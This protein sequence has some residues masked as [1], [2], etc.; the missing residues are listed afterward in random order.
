[1]T[2]SFDLTRLLKLDPNERPRTSLV[3]GALV[4]ILAIIALLSLTHGAVSIPAVRVADIL[5]RAATVRGN[6]VSQDVLVVLN[7]RLP[8]LLLGGFVGASLGMSG[9]LMQGLFR[10][11]LADPGLVG[12][13][14][15]AGLAAAAAI[16]LGDRMLAGSTGVS[17]FSLLP[18][19]AFLG[20]LT[21]TS[22]LYALAT[23]GGRTST[24]TML[25]AGVALAALAGS[26]TGVL[27][28]ISD[29][30]QLR[31]LTFWSMGSLGGATWIKAAVLAPIAAVLLV[32]GPFLS[33]GLNALALGEAEAFHL[34]T[35]VQR[36]K[37]ATIALISLAVGASVAAAGVISFVGIV[38]PHV[39]RLVVGP[40]H[41]RLLPLSVGA[42]A[43]LLT[44]ADLLARLLAAP[45]ELPIGILTAAIG[46]PFLL[47]LLTRHNGSVRF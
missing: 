29:D 5:F 42:G 35:R 11:P 18:A 40:D 10:N 32:S 8:R 15:G 4:A 23:R 38:A 41:R 21:S 6:D 43:T 3:G 33:R 9:A 20:A 46:A 27:T 45:A 26:M 16:V 17:S 19:A 24:A 13:S 36:L 28:Y 12:V 34:G 25:L 14:A 37:I 47:W 39:L 22:I 7:I 2:F 31:D 30:R 44:G 1:M